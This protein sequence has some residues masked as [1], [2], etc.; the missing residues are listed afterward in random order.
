[1]KVHS[2][3]ISED[4][5]AITH[6]IEVLAMFCQYLNRKRSIFS[7]FPNEMTQASQVTILLTLAL[8]QNRLCFADFQRLITL[9]KQNFLKC[10]QNP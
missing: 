1:M 7:N 4:S 6:C 8:K 3:N 5:E 10:W 9:G 2:P